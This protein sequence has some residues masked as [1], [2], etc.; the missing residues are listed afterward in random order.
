MSEVKHSVYVVK[1]LLP[2]RSRAVGDRPK[3]FYQLIYLTYCARLCA[4]YRC[5]MVDN[6]SFLLSQDTHENM[7]V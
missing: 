2:S 1:A 6:T 5:G 7:G 3:G 4:R